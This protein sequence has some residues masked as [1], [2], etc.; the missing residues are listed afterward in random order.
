MDFAPWHATVIQIPLKKNEW[1]KKKTHH[2]SGKKQVLRL[3][4]SPIVP[5]LHLPS[6][7]YVYHDFYIAESKLMTAVHSV[8]HM[9]YR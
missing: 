9:H 3:M 8:Q 1:T 7:I 6:V 4:S 5:F 2:N